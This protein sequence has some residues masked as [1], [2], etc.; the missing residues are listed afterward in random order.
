[1]LVTN[2]IWIQD[3][4]ALTDCL[5]HLVDLMCH[6]GR[7]PCVL[8]S[9]RWWLSREHQQWWHPWSHVT[10]EHTWWQT[11]MCP[12]RKQR[13]AS[14]DTVVYFRRASRISRLS[15]SRSK[16]LSS[17]VNQILDYI[18]PSLLAHELCVSCWQDK[19]KSLEELKRTQQD[20]SMWRK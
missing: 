6:P 8:G 17:H 10:W 2:W 3:R 13:R 7:R 19:E 14:A 18:V 11:L 5:S 1:M 15:K 12:A 9:K 20:G 4:C 16:P